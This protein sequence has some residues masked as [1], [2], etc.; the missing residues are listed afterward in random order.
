MRGLK[1]WK[2]LW[3]VKKTAG[4]LSKDKTLSHVRIPPLKFI[5]SKLP[6]QYPSFHFFRKV[7]ISTAIVF[8][9]SKNGL[10]NYAKFS[11][12]DFCPVLLQMKV[13]FPVMY[14]LFTLSIFNFNSNAN[15]HCL[16]LPLNFANCGTF[17]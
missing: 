1:A 13:R 17:F 10:K 11:V 2:N 14:L 15:I 4:L 3:N 5:P 6:Y 12:L 16:L 9:C 7:V 8:Y